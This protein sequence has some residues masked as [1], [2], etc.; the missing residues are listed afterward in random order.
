MHSF[1]D[2]IMGGCQIQFT[3]SVH[4]HTRTHTKSFTHILTHMHTLTDTHISPWK[5]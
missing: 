2:Y 1:L 3:V 4:T 5:Q